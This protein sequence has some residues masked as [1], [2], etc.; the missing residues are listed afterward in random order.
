MYRG[1]GDRKDRNVGNKVCE[2]KESEKQSELVCATGG[3][4]HEWGVD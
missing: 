3:K 4:G 2:T 1:V